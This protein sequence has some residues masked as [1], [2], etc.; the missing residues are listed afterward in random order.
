M[1]VRWDMVKHCAGILLAGI[2]TCGSMV[3]VYAETQTEPANGDLTVTGAVWDESDGTA[4][5]DEN[6][7]ARYYQVR[8]YRGSSSVTG[9]RETKE[10][11]YEF[12]EDITR[13]GDYHFEVRA[14]G[15]GS[16]KGDW[17]SSYNWYVTSS[18]AEDLGGGY[19]GGPG[20]GTWDSNHGPG[21]VGG[22][23]SQSSGSGPGASGGAYGY[24]TPGVTTGSGGHWCL[25]PYGWWYQYANNTYPRN[26]WQC[27]DGLWYCFNE[28]GYI[29][30]GWIQKDNKWYYCGS[31]GALM[32][33]TRTPDGYYVGGDGVWIP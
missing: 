30:Y 18:E 13:R 8:L 21:V 27:I 23:Y 25:D 17:T 6:P 28:S 15:N 33:N 22:V 20:S 26:C 2:L 3:S 12:E 14:V 10:H 31:D 32:A 7:N 19:S 5:W 16:E 29:R 4:K 24:S 1:R 9:T 11:Y